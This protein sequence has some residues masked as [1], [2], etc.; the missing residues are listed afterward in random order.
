MSA[1]RDRP[2]DRRDRERR[3]AER[4]PPARTADPARGLCPQCQHVK[5]VTTDRGSTFYMC[6][7]SHDD[8]R[9]TR[10]PPQPVVAC[11]GFER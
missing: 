8:R 4:Q 7:R 1:N 9:F 5:V 11:T 10:Y 2:A 3:G 6:R